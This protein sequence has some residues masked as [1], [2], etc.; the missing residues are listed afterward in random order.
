M[1]GVDG[2]GRTG[3]IPPLATISACILV[4]TVVA[5]IDDRFNAFSR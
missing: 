4:M 1:V 2:E 3:I 5:N